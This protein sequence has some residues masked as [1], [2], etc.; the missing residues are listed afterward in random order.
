VIVGQRNSVLPALLLA[1]AV[2]LVFAAGIAI[3]LWLLPSRGFA[4]DIDQ[5]VLW[6][7]GIAVNGWG[8]A[9]DQDLSFPAVMAWIWGALA[10]LEPAFRTVTDASDP[11]IAALMKVPA[12]LA[13]LGIAMAVGWWFR[14]RPWAAVAAMAAILLWPVTWYVSAWWGQYESIYVLPAVLALLAARAGRP[15]LVAALLAVSLMTKPQALPFLVPFAAWFLATQGVRGSLKGALVFA[16]VAAISWLPFIPANG[17][18]NYLGN[19]RDY[20]D[21]VFSVLSLRAWN[22][23]WIVQVVGAGGDFVADGTAVLGP[24][25]FRDIGYAFA[26]V[27]ALVVFAG[28]YRRPSPQGLA[29]GLAAITL[30]AFTALTTMHERYAYPAFVFLLMAANGRVLAVAWVVFSVAF[31]ANLVFAAPAPELSLPDGAVISVAGALVI[32]LTTIV[33]LLWTG[34]TEPRAPYDD[35]GQPLHSLWPT[36]R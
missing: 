30:V 9:Y 20:Q 21:G 10:A 13:D 7:H 19:L 12:S 17:P 18:L 16:A 15:S 2:P 1:V 28:V 26:G 6:V 3:R 27:L 34:R 33:A 8:N 11:A 35:V 14:D 31:L 5:F 32:T 23:W 25:T 4:G 22:P 29:L 36:V 24:L